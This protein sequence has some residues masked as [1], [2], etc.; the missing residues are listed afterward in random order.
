MR[1]FRLALVTALTAFT[2]LLS[3]VFAAAPSSASTSLPCTPT[4]LS[5]CPKPG[6]YNPYVRGGKQPVIYNTTTPWS[7]KVTWLH[8]EVRKPPRGQVP[9][10]LW[11]G[12]GYFNYTNSPQNYTCAGVSNPGL[13]KEWFYRNGKVIGYVPASET[14]CSK[15]PNLTFTVAPGGAYQVY[16]LF[17]N[18]PWR[19]DMVSI[20]WGSVNPQAHPRSPFVNPYAS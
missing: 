3:G 5:W 6:V 13:N 14:T 8:S 9:Q 16:A 15:Y 7:F 10:W 18:V 17:H 12:I 19:G 4:H 11:V 1:T 2:L 20:E